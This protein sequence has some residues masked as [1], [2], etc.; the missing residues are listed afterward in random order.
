MHRVSHFPNL[1]MMCS[2]TLYMEAGSPAFIT[3]IETTPSEQTIREAMHA[4]TKVSN[5]HAVVKA[6]GETNNF[7]LQPWMPNSPEKWEA[8]LLHEECEYYCLLDDLQFCT[9][10][11]HLEIEKLRLPKTGEWHS[12][13]ILILNLYTIARL[14]VMPMDIKQVSKWQDS[15]F[16]P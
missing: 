14:Q 7:N 6:L 13:S 4:N 10:L 11:H 2:Q 5:A 15:A 12:N 8:L 9:M 16:N 1:T 3:A